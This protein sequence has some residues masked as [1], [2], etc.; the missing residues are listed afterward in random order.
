MESSLNKMKKK[1]ILV[2]GGLG[3]IGSHTSINL[4]EEGYKLIIV[5][6]LCNSSLTVL[7]NIYKLTSIKPVFYKCNITNLK[8]LNNIFSNHKI[9]GIMHFA[10]LKSVSES[11]KF[12]NKYFRNNVEGLKILLKCCK[13]HNVNKFIFSSSCTVYGIPKKLP[14]TESFP[15]KKPLS[16]YGET[17]IISEEILIDFTKSHHSFKNISIRYFNPVGAHNS[18]TIGEIPIGIPNNLVPAITQTCIGKIK[19]LKV[20]GKDY[21]TKDGTAL[22]DYIHI[23]DLARAHLKAYKYL[24]KLSKKNYEFFNIGTGKGHTVLEVINTFEKIIKKKL[25]YRF[26]GK[27][28]G[29]VEKIYADVRK[30]NKLLRWKANY[31]L[32]EMLKSAWL[33]EKKLND[34]KRNF[35][36]V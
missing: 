16:P 22:R 28:R 30:A 35:G 32:E 20:F 34:S 36:N 1:T 4:I 19:E 17:K 27:R 3:Y 13:R 6:N 18:I 10:A 7:D 33:W 26:V 25:K 21:N 15:F 12:P 8:E 14:V 29:D 2:T 23:E 24:D 11:L 31:N 9:D 5:D